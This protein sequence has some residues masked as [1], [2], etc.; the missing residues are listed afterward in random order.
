M[1]IVSAVSKRL[2]SAS[3]TDKHGLRSLD[4]GTLRRSSC[5]RWLLPSWTWGHTAHAASALVL[6]I[7]CLL[8]SVSEA[9]SRM[10]V[11][12]KEKGH[13]GLSPLCYI[14]TTRSHS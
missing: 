1:C 12:S 10:M 9:H 2:S 13:Q 3:L 11:L 8:L 14:Y 4:G 5:S 6:R 7:L